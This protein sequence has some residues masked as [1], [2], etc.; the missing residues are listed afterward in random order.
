MIISF[1]YPP[2]PH[3]KK[4]G[5]SKL[6]ATGHVPLPPHPSFVTADAMPSGGKKTEKEHS[7][8]AKSSEPHV[9]SEL[10]QVPSENKER[11]E[12][13]TL[14]R[15]RHWKDKM[16][17]LLRGSNSTLSYTRLIRYCNLVVHFAYFN[18]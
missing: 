7:E 4:N 8:L 11:E 12:A 1:F 2:P 5:A 9:A 18:Q 14:P 15:D 16:T 10:R 3:K 17:G 13:G 6:Q